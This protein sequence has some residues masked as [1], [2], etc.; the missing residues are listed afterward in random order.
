MDGV[1]QRRAMLGGSAQER[2][3]M[4]DVGFRQPVWED[5]D[6][7][8]KLKQDEIELTRKIF[9]RVDPRS[10]AVS[11]LQGAAARHNIDP[12]WS[13]FHQ[14]EDLKQQVTAEFDEYQRIVGAAEAKRVRGTSGRPTGGRLL[15]RISLLGLWL[16]GLSGAFVLIRSPW[17]TRGERWLPAHEA[18]SVSSATPSPS[19]LPLPTNLLADG[20]DG[21]DGAD[22]GPNVVES[23]AASATIPAASNWIF[24]DPV[25]DPPGFRAFQRELEAASAGETGRGP[26][27]RGGG[28]GAGQKGRGGTGRYW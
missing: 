14:V 5:T 28:C 4:G 8:K 6:A 22:L 9:A 23:A 11:N 25:V 20:A 3:Q 27:G 17:P 15:R 2:A 21:A 10:D 13:P 12:Y 16:L 7:I 19:S 24:Q 26:K 1:R 18:E